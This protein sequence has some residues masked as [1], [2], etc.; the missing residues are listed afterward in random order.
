[1][2]LFFLAA[3]MG[4]RLKPLTEKYPKPCVPFLNVPLGY[5]NFRFLRPNLASRCVANTF[6]LPAQI[7]SLYK[8]QNWFKTPFSFSDEEGFILGGAGGLKK[9][10]PLFKA[11]EPILMM[12]ADEVYFPKDRQFIEKA[13]EQHLKN[14][15]LATLVCMEHPEAGKKFGAIWCDGIHVKEVGKSPN[16]PNLKPLHFIGMILL[17]PRLLDIIPQGVEA[18]IFYDGILKCIDTDRVE[19]FTIFTD[20]YETGN[21]ADYF[22][23]TKLSLENLL[24]ETLE[25]INHFDPSRVVKN[26]SGISLVS[27]SVSVDESRL[28]G[29]NVISKSTNPKTLQSLGRIENTVLFE[30]EVV[31]ENYF[32]TN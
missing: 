2:N 13:L 6:Y 23:A 19:V 16:N 22:E 18:N 5:Y 27:N 12:N 25:F 31:N 20:W 21:P 4:S 3:G 7:H 29:F 9:A 1:M 28:F 10:A 30:N 8:N 11:G 14:D 24:P 32:K 17:H 15:N 26:A